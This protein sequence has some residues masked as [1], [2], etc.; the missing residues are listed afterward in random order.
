VQTKDTLLNSNCVRLLC[1]VYVLNNIRSN[2]IYSPK[3]DHGKLQTK[4]Y[5]LFNPLSLKVQIKV[6]IYKR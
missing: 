5:T 1:H 3:N 2:L 4:Y 6:E